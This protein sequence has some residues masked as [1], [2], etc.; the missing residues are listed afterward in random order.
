MRYK[1]YEEHG[2]F[3]VASI[4]QISNDDITIIS[5]SEFIH[6]GL[7]VMYSHYELSLI[8]IKNHELLCEMSI[9][10]PNLYN[11][12]FVYAYIWGLF[13]KDILLCGKDKIGKMIAN[14][15]GFIKIGEFTESYLANTLTY[16]LVYRDNRGIR[17][18][19][20]SE[21]A[22]YLVS[23]Y[24][25]IKPT[26]INI[27]ERSI[28]VDYDIAFGLHDFIKSNVK[29]NKPDGDLVPIIPTT[30]LKFKK[31]KYDKSYTSK[32]RDNTIRYI[33][34]DECDLTYC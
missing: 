4:T 24:K 2:V 23:L 27:H 6:T 22:S 20:E 19:I 11:E 12:E 26:I 34:P 18:L 17:E 13:I 8:I 30:H 10:R 14:Y 3:N 7:R 28:Y 25:D 1:T 29:V 32:G 31:H 33:Y 16:D 5:Q 15:T 9:S 21:M